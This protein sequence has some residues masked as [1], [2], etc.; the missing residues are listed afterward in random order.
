MPALPPLSPDFLWGVSLALLSLLTYGAC[1]VAI[2]VVLQGM[3]SGPGSLVAAAAGVPVGLLLAVLQLAL[4]GG[5][6]MPSAWAVCSFALA[7][8]CSTYLGRWLTF[9]SI[10]LIG[11]SSAAGLQSTSPMITAVFGSIFLG[12]AIGVTGFAGMGLGMLGL[13]A[14]SLG[15]QAQRPATIEAGAAGPGRSAPA[16]QG[17]FVVGTMLIGLVA[18]ASYSG[19]HIFRASAVR[20]WNEPLLGATIGSVA[21]LLVLAIASRKQLAEHL[22]D[23]RSRR[24]PTAVYFAV[25]TL[26]FAAQALVIASMRYI[27]ASL[28]ALISMCT[29]LAVM[30]IS[31]LVLRK[32]ETLNPATV[33]GICITLTGMALVVLYGPG[34]THG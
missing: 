1:M 23:I 34:R 15:I 25:G 8:I 3:G 28:A 24:G 30:P 29:P 4:R 10:E 27:P 12:E 5:V 33:L 31:Y 14:M 13:A 11:P 7:G 32:R 17:G 21:G 9:K 2:S 18:A 26:Q 22:H 16:R 20:Q 6:E 19:S